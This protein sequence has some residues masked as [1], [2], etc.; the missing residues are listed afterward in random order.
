MKKEKNTK[1]VL[2]ERK[3]GLE[4]YLNERKCLDLELGFKE[5]IKN[6]QEDILK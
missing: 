2:K 5:K 3:N 6:M 1:E 4:E